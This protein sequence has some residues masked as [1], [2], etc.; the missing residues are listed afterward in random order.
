MSH[1]LGIA[2]D[3]IVLVKGE[4]SF[5]GPV[6]ELGDLSERLLAAPPSESES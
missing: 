1:A 4:I 6:A 3:V 5:Y 2:D